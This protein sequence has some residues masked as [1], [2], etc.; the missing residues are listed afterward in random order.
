MYRHSNKIITVLLFSALFTISSSA[1]ADCTRHFYN[2]SSSQWV[3][4][5][6]GENPN[7]LNIPAGATIPITY[8]ISGIPWTDAAYLTVQGPAYSQSF[9]IEARLDCVYLDHD[10]NTGRALLNDPANGDITFIN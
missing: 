8:G 7:H 10:G 1:R 4:T 5:F 2:Q 6:G 9:A 3:V